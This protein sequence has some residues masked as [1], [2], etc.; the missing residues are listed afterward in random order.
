[1]RP[2]RG[3]IESKEDRDAIRTGPVDTL[4]EEFRTRLVFKLHF[5]RFPIKIGPSQAAPEQGTGPDLG[6]H[7]ALKLTCDSG[8]IGR[9]DSPAGTESG[10]DH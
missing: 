4:A 8:S 9:R 3:F 5:Y 1:M 6:D 7:T 10:A 2:I